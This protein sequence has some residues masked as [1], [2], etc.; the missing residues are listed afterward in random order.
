MDT[1]KETERGVILDVR[2]KPGVSQTLLYKKE[3]CLILEVQS[4]PEKN[5]ANIEII[6]YLS[7]LFNRGVKIIR[8]LKSRNKAVFIENM[9]KEE[10]DKLLNPV[11]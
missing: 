10:L 7:K 5:K 9:T 8:G 1:I 11:P 6:N 4:E 3:D 2:V